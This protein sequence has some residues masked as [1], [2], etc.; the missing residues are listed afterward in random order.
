MVT[1]FKLCRDKAG[2]SE[3]SCAG[4]SE[5]TSEKFTRRSDLF[6]R[7][8]IYRVSTKVDI[9]HQSI[10]SHLFNIT[11]ISVVRFNRLFMSKIYGDRTKT[12]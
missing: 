1:I 3:E 8:A 10:R 12:M 11:I 9:T 6:T 2:K 7:R 5:E 4:F